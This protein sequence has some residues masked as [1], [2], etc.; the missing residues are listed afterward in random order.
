L[1]DV[2]GDKKSLD[3][4]DVSKLKYL[5]MCIKETLRL[6]TVAPFVFRETTEDFQLGEDLDLLAAVRHFHFRENYNTEERDGGNWDILRT[7]R[8]DSL[9]E[10]Q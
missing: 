1:R 3:M 4:D 7:Q 8:S 2:V 10:A 9:G 6:F 5:E